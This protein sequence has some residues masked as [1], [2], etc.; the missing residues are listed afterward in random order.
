M[1]SDTIEIQQSLNDTEAV[2]NLIETFIAMVDNTEYMGINYSDVYNILS[3]LN[4]TIKGL[5]KNATDAY[6]QLI[7]QQ[8]IVANLTNDIVT[9]Q[10]QAMVYLDSLNHASNTSQD[11]MDMVSTVKSLMPDLMVVDTKFSMAEDT[12]LYVQNGTAV[13]NASFAKLQSDFAKLNMSIEALSDM[14]SNASAAVAAL[15][16]DSTTA[17]HMASTNLLMVEQLMVGD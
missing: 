1:L 8:S 13:A 7:L 11:A 4:S 16:T 15:E 10:M 2:L 14:L 3:Y 9:F 12:L 5:H 6:S 17:L